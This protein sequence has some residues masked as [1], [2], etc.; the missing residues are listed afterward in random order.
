[1]EYITVSRTNPSGISMCW[2]STPSRVAP[3]RSIARCERVLRGVRFQL[4]P[5]RPEHFKSTA[6]QQQ[7]ALGIDRGTPRGLPE[8]GAPISKR[9]CALETSM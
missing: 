9:R 5:V 6:Q 1:M 3:S 8:P 2:R 7:L 4:H